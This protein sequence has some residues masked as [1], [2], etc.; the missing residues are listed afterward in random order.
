MLAN[1]LLEMRKLEVERS[2]SIIV[3]AGVMDAL[4]LYLGRFYGWQ[5]YCPEEVRASGSCRDHSSTDII[6]DR[7]LAPGTRRYSRDAVP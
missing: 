3:Q 2:D 6:A 1:L 7:F 4:V 5:V